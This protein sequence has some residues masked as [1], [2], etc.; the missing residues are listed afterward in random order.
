MSKLMT[1]ESHIY[2]EIGREFAS[3]EAVNH[4][5]YEWGRAP[6]KSEPKRVMW[7]ALGLPWARRGDK[8]LAWNRLMRSARHF[9]SPHLSRHC[10]EERPLCALERTAWASRNF[11][12]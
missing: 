11:V 1:D 9:R 7:M 6:D 8:S 2:K 5:I 12:R 4:S 10:I 3:H